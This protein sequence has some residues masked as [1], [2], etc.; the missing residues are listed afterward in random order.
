MTLTLK[1][2]TEAREAAESAMR[3]AQFAVLEAEAERAPFAAR[4]QETLK[5]L[6]PYDEEIAL[7]QFRAKK[8]AEAFGDAWTNETKL[9][10]KAAR[11]KSK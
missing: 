5:E 8:A 10:Q 1:E 3:E 4:A 11:K 2:A 9:L 7:T 6:K